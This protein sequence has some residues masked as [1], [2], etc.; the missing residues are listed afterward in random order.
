MTREP[1]I[2][3]LRRIVDGHTA[4]KVD[5]ITIDTTTAGMLVAVYEALGVESRMRFDDPPLG[6]LIEF[7]WKHTTMRG[8]AG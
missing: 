3:Q 6:R 8:G 2:V 1:R 4:G 7:G 5:G